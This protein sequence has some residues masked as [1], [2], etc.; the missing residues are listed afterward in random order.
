M[1]MLY[2]CSHSHARFI[3]QFINMCPNFRELTRLQFAI[4][5]N[6]ANNSRPTV[7]VKA[8]TRPISIYRKVKI[9]K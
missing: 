9:K 8:A 7:T 5:K 3:A 2:D 6:L 1:F 4:I